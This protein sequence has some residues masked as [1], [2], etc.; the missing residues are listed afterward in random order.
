MTLSDRSLLQALEA[1]IPILEEKLHV[2][3]A[4]RKRL[5]SAETMR[6]NR[7]PGGGPAATEALRRYNASP[8]GKARHAALCRA[9]NERK[10]LPFAKGTKAYRRYKALTRKGVWTRAEA[11]AKVH[12][13]GGA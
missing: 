1:E 7:K 4:T 3:K 13:E 8:E 2:L 10:K 12:A 11:I 5:K 6:R 9:N